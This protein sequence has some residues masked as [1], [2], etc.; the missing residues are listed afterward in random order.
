VTRRPI[1]IWCHYPS[2]VWSCQPDRLWRAPLHGRR[3]YIM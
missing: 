3:F 2:A 1:H